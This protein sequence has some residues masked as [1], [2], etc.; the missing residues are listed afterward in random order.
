VGDGDSGAGVELMT[1]WEFLIWGLA[2]CL[3]IIIVLV[4]LVVVAIVARAV[5]EVVRYGKV[6]K[7]G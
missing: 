3:V 6:Q 1:P 4:A 2:W 7:R 5:Y